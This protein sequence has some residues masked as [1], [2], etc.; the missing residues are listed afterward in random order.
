MI[1]LLVVAALLLGGAIGAIAGRRRPAH[2][3]RRAGLDAARPD[4]QT[5]WTNMHGS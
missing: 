4:V 1:G 2:R 5:G 3:V